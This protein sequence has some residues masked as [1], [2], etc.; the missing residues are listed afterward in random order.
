M[1]SQNQNFSIKEINPL[2]SL[3]EWEEDISRK[4]S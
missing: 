1:Q 2:Q 4:I 3:D